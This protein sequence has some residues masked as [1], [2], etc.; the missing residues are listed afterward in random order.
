[1]DTVGRG[2]L[3][4]GSHTHLNFSYLSVPL[5]VA[6]ILSHTLTHAHSE[7]SQTSHT[8]CHL[9]LSTF[10]LS[11]LFPS[12]QI[13]TDSRLCCVHAVFLVSALDTGAAGTLKESRSVCHMFRQRQFLFCF[14]PAHVTL[15][16]VS[17]S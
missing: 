16:F 5:L 7:T 10:S 6:C 14:F 1:M 9:R 15:C 4:D 12:L 17:V 2:E 11:L 3:L 13:F 8:K